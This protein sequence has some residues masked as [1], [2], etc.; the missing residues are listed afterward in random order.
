VLPAALTNGGGSE[1]SLTRIGQI[2]RHFAK[3]FSTNFDLSL[4]LNLFLDAISEFLHPSRAS[5]LVRHPLTRHYEIRAYR[6]LAPQVAE[7]LRLR[8]DEGIPRWLLTEGRLLHRGEVA[9]SC[10]RRILD[11]QREMQALKALVSIL[12]ASGTLIT[13]SISA[14]G[15]PVRPTPMMNSKSCLV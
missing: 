12:M 7:H 9:S 2:L 14:S 3:A 6:G 15:S 13:F 8:P 5:I 4:T 11:I 1:L 10:V